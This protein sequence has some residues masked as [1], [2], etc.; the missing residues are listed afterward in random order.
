MFLMIYLRLHFFKNLDQISENQQKV[1]Y[2]DILVGFV[3]RSFDLWNYEV[4]NI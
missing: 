3:V 1:L 2:R 4:F